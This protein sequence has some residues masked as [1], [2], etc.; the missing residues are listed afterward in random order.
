MAGV[1]GKD[2]EKRKK[3]PCLTGNNN[4]ECLP[5]Y[6]FGR[7]DHFPAFLTHRGGVKKSIIDLMRPLF[8]C[9]VK[10]NR[11]ANLLKELHAKKHMQHLLD[12]EREYKCD[13]RLNPL[14]TRP[15]YSTPG[16]KN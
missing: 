1:R 16:N 10:P 6:P 12:Y 9:G 2:R 5:L 4:P 14:L 11:F 13:L 7:G 3:R 8:N 15:E